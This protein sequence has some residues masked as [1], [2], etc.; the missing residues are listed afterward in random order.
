MAPVVPAATAPVVLQVS[1]RLER[2]VKAAV[3]LVLL[4]SQ[5]FAPT[6]ICRR[7]PGGLGRVGRLDELRK[8]H[9][10]GGTVVVRSMEHADEPPL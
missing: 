4:A 7:L 5:L 3:V 9:G 6:A 10:L 1:V 2:V 8:R